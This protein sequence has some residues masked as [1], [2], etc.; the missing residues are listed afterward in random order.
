M[1]I[2]KVSIIG[3]GIMGMGIAQALAQHGFEVAICD[4]EKSALDKGLVRCFS[5]CK[6]GSF[7]PAHFGRFMGQYLFG[8][9]DFRALQGF[10]PGNLVHWKFS[11]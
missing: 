10:K 9:I 11:E 2:E 3:V 5:S 1:A 6:G 7:A 8:L 4:L